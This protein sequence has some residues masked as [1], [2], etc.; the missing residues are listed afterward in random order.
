M[1]DDSRIIGI[2]GSGIAALRAANA[3]IDT[4]VRAQISIFGEESYRPYRR[5]GLTKER[6]P[7]SANSARAM[8]QNLQVRGSDRAALRWHLGTRVN[9]ANL[10]ARIL[11]LSNGDTFE[12]HRLVVATG[13]RPRRLTQPTTCRSG[14]RRTLRSLD[15]AQFVHNHMREQ[16]PISINGAGF[17]GCELASLA[18]S[19]GCPAVTLISH[20]NGPFHRALGA[21]VSGALRGWVVENGVAFQTSDGS[22]EHLRGHALGITT[23]DHAEELQSRPSL[24]EHLYVDAIGSTPN[25]E[26]LQGNGLDLTN[27][28][29]VDRYMRVLGRNDV[30]AAGDVAQY[31]DPWLQETSTRMESW[32]NSLETGDLAGRSLAASCGF[33]TNPRPINYFPTL[34]TEMFG[35]RIQF[36]G[37][38]ALHDSV[39][40]VDGDLN[41]IG[42]GLLVR[43]NYKQSLIGAAYLDTG[44]RL[45]KDYIQLIKSMKSSQSA[46][47][48]DL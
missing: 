17:L 19:Y 37:R 8:M 38:P 5:P 18:H 28:L 16:R 30:F 1:A 4:G 31:P 23:R 29:P 2:V 36:C 39:E 34:A 48:I 32:K 46:A 14:T 44:A 35:L 42:N 25:V 3:V 22:A 27:G 10:D 45:N 11:R 12:Y 21:D 6:L 9:S 26:W 24:D 15:D 20:Q 7:P 13:V 43:Y 47:S 33:D 40:I 41:R